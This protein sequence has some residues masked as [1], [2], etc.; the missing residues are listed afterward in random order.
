MD[1][2]AQVVVNVSGIE[3][4][5][6]YHIPDEFQNDLQIGS[7]I[8]VPFGKQIVQGIVRSFVE[9]PQVSITKDIHNILDEAPVLTKEQQSLAEWMA[10]ESLSTLS[11][12]YQLMLPPGLS[13]KADRLYKLGKSP[14]NFPLSPLQKRIINRLEE[15]GPQRG[16]QL[17]AVFRRLEWKKIHS[18]A[19][20]A[21]CSF[22][23]TI[24]TTGK[25]PEKNDKKSL[26]SL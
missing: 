11:E 14:G 17:E 26:L 3:G 9:F 19:N 6:D 22:R 15:R 1:Q 7:L 12:C 24:F 13:Q 21:W 18:S 4:V 10:K 8:L 16:R 2:Y 23:T 5:F 20:P 25:S